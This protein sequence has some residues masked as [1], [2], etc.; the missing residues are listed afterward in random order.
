[1]ATETDLKPVQQEIIKQGLIITAIHNHFVRNYMHLGNVGA[2]GKMAE[3]AKAVLDKIKEV[4]GGDPSKGTA[5]A[6][7]VQ[8]TL[9]T[10]NWMTF[11]A[12][13]Q[14]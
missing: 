14:R 4:R 1:M 12:T 13:R 8:N 3:K 2:T 10:K 9:D 7:A 6:E 5:S 11:W